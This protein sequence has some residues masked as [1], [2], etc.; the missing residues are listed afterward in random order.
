MLPITVTV[1]NSFHPAHEYTNRQRAFISHPHE[2]SPSMVS[3]KTAT[4]AQEGRSG[5]S[6]GGTFEMLR[7]FQGNES[8][9]AEASGNANRLGSD[10]HSTL[11]TQIIYS[12]H[13]RYSFPLGEHLHRPSIGHGSR[14]RRTT[15]GFVKF[16]KLGHP[17]APTRR[18]QP[19]APS[20]APRLPASTACC[21]QVLRPRWN[22]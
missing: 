1:H 12:R 5:Y 17:R 11:Q 13:G 10:A 16:L 2:R 18:H 21:R 22:W 19:P 14:F 7:D 4:P 8:W 3:E 6:I 9:I 15:G 20:P